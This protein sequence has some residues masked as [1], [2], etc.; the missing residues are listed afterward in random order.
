MLSSDS[1][2]C[3]C[4]ILLSMEKMK[5]F[6]PLFSKNLPILPSPKIPDFRTICASCLKNRGTKQQKFAILRISAQKPARFL[7]KQALFTHIFSTTLR[8][9]CEQ[10][11]VG[12]Q[13]PAA[14]NQKC[15]AEYGGEIYDYNGY[16]IPEL[17]LG[18]ATRGSVGVSRQR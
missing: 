1:I 8:K 5:F 14:G 6:I 10:P 16:A 3:A 4:T 13:G 2:K 12:S 7:Q 9:L 18:M 17:E 15:L 11:V